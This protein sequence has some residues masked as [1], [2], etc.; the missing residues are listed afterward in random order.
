MPDDAP[1]STAAPDAPP[2]APAGSAAHDIVVVGGGAAGLELATQL[3]DRLGKRGRARVT[4][5]DR[6]RTH[7]WKPLLHSVAAGSMDPGEHELNYM[8]QAHWHHFRYR[9][10]EMTGLDRARHELLLG[11]M[12]D[13]EGRLITPSQRVHYDTLVIAIGSVT[14]DFGTPG[15]AQHAVPLETP[16][17]AARFNRRLVNAL[18]RAQT[19]ESA[20][21]PGQLHVAII[22]AGATGTELAAELHRTS[23]EVVGYGLDRIDPERDIRIVLIEA[24]P[25]I[26]PA[27]PQRVADAT[28]ALLHNLGIEVRTGARVAE[29]Q[30]DG[31]RLADGGFIASELVVWAAGVKGPEVLRDLGGLE[32]NRA[33]QLVVLPTLQTTRDPDVFAIGDCCACPRPGNPLPV[34]PRAQAA[35]QEATHLLRQLPR[36]LAGQAVEPFVYRDFG[37]LVSLGKYSA[38]GS[39]MGFIVGKNMFIEG[40]FARV[41]YRSLYKMHERAL[42]GSAKTVLGSLSRRLSRG[43]EP[44]VKLH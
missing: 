42:Y 22:G 17:Q 3:G 31:V 7:L 28:V 29:V 35:H 25:R 30:A 21:R 38:I 9:L 16:A 39:L 8:A 4:L 15:A 2:A 24:A 6:S 26:L 40:A 10:G 19:Q 37:S 13:D 18:I 20:V 5:I 12:H 44:A 27:L 14:N 43:T 33:N 1:A 36:R 34:P 41:M 32:V 23:R 11:A